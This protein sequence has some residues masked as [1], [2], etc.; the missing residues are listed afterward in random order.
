MT[1]VNSKWNVRKTCPRVFSC[2]RN[3]P[4]V[5]CFLS[6]F[7]FSVLPERLPECV[8][9]GACGS[10]EGIPPGSGMAR[11]RLYSS[12]ATAERGGDGHRSVWGR[13]CTRTSV[14]G[15]IVYDREVKGQRSETTNYSCAMPLIFFLSFRK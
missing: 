9:S 7:L 13:W 5:M 11:A 4:T 2:G 6:F 12:M 15:Q 8:C 1:N 3:G 10:T 14:K